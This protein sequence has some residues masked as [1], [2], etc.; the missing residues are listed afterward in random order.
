MSR[1]EDIQLCL[2]GASLAAG[3]ETDWEDSDF[4]EQSL[5]GISAFSVD[6]PQGGIWLWALLTQRPDS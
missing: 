4:R 3:W 6:L 5:G 2:Q 1:E